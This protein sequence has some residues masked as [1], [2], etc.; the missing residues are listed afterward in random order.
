MEPFGAVGLS[1]M[2]P[3]VATTLAWCAPRTT[4]APRSAHDPV[5]VSSVRRSSPVAVR[6]IKIKGTMNETR[7]ATCEDSPRS[8]RSES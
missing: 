8:S 4:T 1:M 7:H 6:V 2:P 3:V 5:G